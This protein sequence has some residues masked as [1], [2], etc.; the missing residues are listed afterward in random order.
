ML[1]SEGAVLELESDE[2]VIL[3]EEIDAFKS[4]L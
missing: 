4:D 3:D 2:E 1:R